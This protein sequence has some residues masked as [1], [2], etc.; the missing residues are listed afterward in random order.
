VPVFSVSN[1]ILQQSSYLRLGGSEA[2]GALAEIIDGVPFSE[3]SVTENGEWA[4]GLWEVL[5][6]LVS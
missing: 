6:I 3:E 2:D 5:K 1:L 4:Y